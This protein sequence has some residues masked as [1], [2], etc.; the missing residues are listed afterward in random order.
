MEYFWKP[1]SNTP[2]HN[3]PQREGPATCVFAQQHSYATF[4][5]LSFNSPHGKFRRSFKNTLISIFNFL[6]LPNMKLRVP[7]TIYF[8]VAQFSI[9]M[10]YKY[11]Y[12]YY[13]YYYFIFV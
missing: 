13:Y 4:V 1:N 12:Y 11:Y 8:P 9:P 2:E 5:S 7:W 3:R 10:Q 6:K